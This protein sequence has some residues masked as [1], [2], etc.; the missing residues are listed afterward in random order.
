MTSCGQQTAEVYL[1]FFHRTL[2]HAPSLSLHH[3][4]T[5]LN[6]MDG[7]VLSTLEAGL[8]VLQKGTDWYKQEFQVSIA[9]GKRA[10]ADDLT[11]SERQIR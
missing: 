7:E 1:C 10:M 6:N 11:G 3:S 8:A 5:E 2:T 4:A 9:G